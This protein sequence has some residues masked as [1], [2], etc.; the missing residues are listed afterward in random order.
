MDLAQQSAFEVAIR[1]R[2]S[3]F[4]PTWSGGLAADGKAFA[5][6]SHFHTISSFPNGGT[7]RAFV[8]GTLAARSLWYPWQQRGFEGEG[9]RRGDVPSRQRGGRKA[10]E[11]RDDLLSLSVASRSPGEKAERA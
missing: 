6:S 7:N 11:A 4:L 5:S 3:S 8:G 2:S 10:G 1:K 9:Q